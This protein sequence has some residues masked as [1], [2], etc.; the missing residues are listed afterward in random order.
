[1]NYIT[2]EL[3]NEKYKNNTSIIFVNEQLLHTFERTRIYIYIG[4]YNLELDVENNY[5]TYYLK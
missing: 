4:I 2:R 5:T 1:M 3:L